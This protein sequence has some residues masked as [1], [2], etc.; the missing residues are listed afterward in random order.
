MTQTDIQKYAKVLLKRAV[1]LSIGIF[2][3]FSSTI[4]LNV[5]F[6][7]K[8]S[9]IAH[10]INISG[11]Q[12]ML[13]QRLA[14]FKTQNLK[15]DFKK[16]YDLFVE[17][18]QKI[19]KSAPDEVLNYYNKS[20]NSE[21]NQYLT[22]LSQK[23]LSNKKLISQSKT[24]LKSLDIAV[25]KFENYSHKYTQRIK[26]SRIIS[27]IFVSSLI[28]FLYYF[29]LRGQRKEFLFLLNSYSKERAKALEATQAKSV[30]LANM[31]HELRTPLNGIL[32][33]SSN[34]K[35]TKLNEQQRFY[36]ENLIKS[37]NT[38]L[39]IINDVL[40]YS[41]LE[42]Q[43]VQLNKKSFHLES[44]L[45]EVKSLLHPIAKN[46][47]LDLSYSIDQTLPECVFSDP[48]RYK[49]I[50][51]NLANNA[52]KFTKK[53][54]IHI[55]VNCHCDNEVAISVEDTGIGISENDQVKIFQDFEQ[56]ENTYVKTQEGT[57]LGLAITKK[58]IEAMQGSITVTSTENIGTTF[59]VILPFEKGDSLTKRT[60]YNSQ[61]DKVVLR[62]IGKVLIA[63]DNNVNQIVISS[64]LKKLKIDHEIV[65]NGE[66]A[67]EKVKA[68]NYD[69]VLMD[70]SMPVMNGFDATIK[71]RE[72]NLDI[73]IFCL[74]A[75]VFNEDRERAFEVGM[76]EF[77]QKPIQ[78][79]EFITLL[80]K[81][82]SK[83]AA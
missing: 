9:D 8:I 32:G 16:S 17:S 31:S 55:A 27:F 56:V 6:D 11:R 53:G 4:L 62:D 38:L 74:S 72:F 12:R 48:L 5:Y 29:I 61:N 36:L 3:A 77:L 43:D 10:L 51:M 7:S 75:N 70:I 35:E 21:F 76:N 66:L 81:Y 2:V 59:Q 42:S 47:G 78:K 58:I 26:Q 25:T 64:F 24:I 54:S 73:P 69:L 30:F 41:K 37:G 34:L 13:S 33:L 79:N 45:G 15:N 60:S 1:L 71:I 50:L 18:H 46:K 14:F 28:L 63:E 22:T 65:E 23:E 80:N 20:L 83:K 68:H 57:G 19:I 82:V 39:E 49:Q 44:L 40:D 52:I 67:V